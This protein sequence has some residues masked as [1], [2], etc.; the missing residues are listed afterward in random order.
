[1][2]FLASGSPNPNISN[3][4][5]Y[6]IG[7]FIRCECSLADSVLANRNISTKKKL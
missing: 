4:L 2:Y 1:M 5:F 6:R 7:T 3:S